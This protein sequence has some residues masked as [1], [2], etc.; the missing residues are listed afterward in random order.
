MVFDA[1]WLWMNQ[2]DF[3]HPT[4]GQRLVSSPSSALGWRIAKAKVIDIPNE[5]GREVGES[6]LVDP[7]PA[8]LHPT[9]TVYGSRSETTERNRGWLQVEWTRHDDGE[10]SDRRHVT[11]HSWGWL[12]RCRYDRNESDLSTTRRALRRD[13]SLT[14]VEYFDVMENEA[15]CFTLLDAVFQ[16]GAAIVRCAPTG[17]TFDDGNHEAK[18][19]ALLGKRLSGGRLSHGHLYGD[20]FHVRSVP[21]AINLAYTS[22]PLPPHQDLAYYQSPPGLQLLH[23]VRNRVESGGESTL[24]DAIAATEQLQQWMPDRFDVLARCCATFVKQRETA[25]MVFRAPHIHAIPKSFSSTSE[26]KNDG[27]S[28]SAPEVVAVRWAPPFQGPVLI[29]PDILKGYWSAYMCLERMLDNSIRTDTYLQPCDVAPEDE[30][31]LIAYAHQHTWERRLE[32]GEVLVFNNQRILHGR[33]GFQ[34]ASGDNESVGG[35]HFI[36]C[37]TNMEDTL[38]RY[39]LLWRQYGFQKFGN[40]Y[41]PAVGNGSTGMMLW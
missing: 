33:R 19:V 7:P 31:K 23:C 40:S 38:S 26:A 6:H 21:D 37:Y 9:G 14:E 39:R 22:T 11:H 3:V 35:R 18:T 30:Q 32:E 24:I 2:P 16:Q 15:A 27:R 28:A 41:V 17:N 29:D 25:D 34:L 8:C 5:D 1:T 20:T 4:S 36:G 12:E 13:S 10:L